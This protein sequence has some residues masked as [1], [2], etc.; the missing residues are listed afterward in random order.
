M[1]KKFKNTIRAL[2]LVMALAILPAGCGNST[3]ASDGSSAPAPASNAAAQSSADESKSAADASAPATDASSKPADASAQG[4]GEARTVTDAFGRKVE[5][6]AQI[7]TVAPL[8]NALRLMCYLDANDLVAGV[9]SGEKK[10]DLAKAYNHVYHEKWKDLPVIGEGGK[11]GYTPYVEELVT[12]APDVIVTSGYEVKD[13]ED[14][15]EKTGIPVVGV[16]AGTI[17]EPDYAQSIQIIGEAIG[18]TERAEKVLKFIQDVK[19]DLH[20]RTKNIPDDKKPSC[21]T[22]AVSFRGPH[23]IDGSYQNFPPFVA[24]NAKNVLEADG[25][26]AKGVVVDKEFILEKDPDVIFLDPNNLKMVKDDY[27]Q[28]P[29]FYKSLKAFKD[30]RVYTMLGYNWY[31]TNLEIAMADC[32]YAG[33]VLYPD[34][35]KDVDPVA[36]ANEIYTFM[37]NAPNY[38]SELDQA[39][40]G[41]G[42]IKLW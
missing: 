11:G 20:D 1:I 41:F 24:I 33:S 18:R 25:K 26:A 17:F 28:N 4:S 13:V 22:G 38:Y 30:G 23:G 21:Y 42:E 12:L 29:D 36:K 39:G 40:L 15:A 9:E 6:P 8:G 32:Y 7:K 31:Y 34:A 10:T 3:P 19:D 5:L 16:K 35:F 14:L 27:A 2:A 37:L